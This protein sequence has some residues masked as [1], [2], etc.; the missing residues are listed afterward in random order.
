MVRVGKI[1]R[2]IETIAPLHLALQ[3]D[4]CGLQLGSPDRPV[5]GILVALDPSLEA[6]RRAVAGKANL[7]VTH[8]PLF[9]EPIRQ[10]DTSTSTGA[11]AALAISK[12]VAV[13]SAHTS[14]DAA[15]NGLARELARRAGLEDVR[16]FPPG[17]SERWFK[18]AVFVPQSMRE[19]IH[20]AMADAGAGALGKYDRCAFVTAGEGIF[21][22]L[23]GSRPAIGEKGTTEKVS[24]DRLEMLVEEKDVPAVI[25]A[26]KKIHPYEEVAYDLYPLRLPE[27]GGI[28][29]VGKRA[30]TGIRGLAA[31]LSR[32]FRAE[33]RVSGRAP[34][35]IVRAAVV[36]GSGGGY[37]H[38]AARQGAEVLITGE[39]RYHQ[40]LEAEHLGM[41]VIELGHD[42][43][44]MPA[45]DLMAG[46]LRKGL[47]KEMKKI[48]VGTFKRPRT[49]VSLE[50]Q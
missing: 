35:R 47:G 36:P 10:L 2:I 37:L 8:H 41:G 32:S 23:G 34:G 18:L 39:V 9:Y 40:M 17:L 19:K 16:F 31:E 6:V 26:M 22:P 49:A 14:L 30:G 15:P 12:G 38:D 11:A 7:L 43:S 50:K 44:E 25:E 45:V 21:R 24:E 20:R 3:G 28:G 33:A 5:R 46:A 27:Q 1:A 48:R 13:Y 4:N 42:R 29:C